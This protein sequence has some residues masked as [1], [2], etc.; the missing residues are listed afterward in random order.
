MEDGLIGKVFTR[1]TVVIRGED[2]TCPGSK[3]TAAR[4]ICR[5]ICGKEKLVHK[6]HLLRETSKSCG[7]LTKDR[8]ITHGMSRTRGYICWRNMRR[9]VS[10]TTGHDSLNYL[11]K[12]ITICERWERSFLNFLEDMGECPLGLELDRIDVTGNYEPSNCRWAT[13]QV[14]AA[15]RGMFVTNTSGTVGVTL[16]RNY[17][18]SGDSNFY[19]RGRVVKDGKEIRQDFSI[20]KL[21]EREA[22]LLACNW[23][24]ENSINPCN[25]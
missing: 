14:Q 19:W 5:C 13:E 3:V 4:Y 22:Y 17:L 2:Y 20:N 10:A 12:G 15:N 25:R 21:G 16:L 18:K 11:H 7:C 1:W 9:R 23:R 24:E 6:A 8:L